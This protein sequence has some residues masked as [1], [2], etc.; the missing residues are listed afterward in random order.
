MNQPVPIKHIEIWEA[1]PL[2]LV[3]RITPAEGDVTVNVLLLPPEAVAIW[4][5]VKLLF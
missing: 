4:V 2:V 3:T 1:P 5:A